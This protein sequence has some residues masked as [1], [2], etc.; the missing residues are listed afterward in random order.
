MHLRVFVAPAPLVVLDHAGE[1]PLFVGFVVTFRKYILRIYEGMLEDTVVRMLHHLF[2]FTFK[3]NSI[4]IFLMPFLRTTTWSVKKFTWPRVRTGMPHLYH[5]LLSS[6]LWHLQMARF[7]ETEGARSHC[8]GQAYRCH[9]PNG[10][11]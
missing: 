1:I 6:S 5:I 9:F 3:T 10:L 11:R 7:S 4:E 8:V 2:F